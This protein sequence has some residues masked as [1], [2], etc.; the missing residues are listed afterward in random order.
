MARTAPPIQ[1]APFGVAAL[2]RW[3]RSGASAKDQSAA[4][5]AAGAALAALDPLAQS[6]SPPA[7]LWRDRLA[8][9]AAA[10]LCRIE[11]AR[12][13]LPE[14]RDHWCLRQP[15]DDPGPAGRRFAAFRLLGDAR[16]LRRCDW[17]DRL[18]GLFDLPPGEPLRRALAEAAAIGDTLPPPHA[19]AQAAR[20]I[21]TLGPDCRGLALWVGDAVLARTL[22][23]HRPL[24]LA[25]TA[26]PRKVLTRPEAGD[27]DSAWTTAIVQAAIGAHDLYRSL[28]TR[29]SALLD[30]APRLRGR[31][32][33]ATIS[34]LLAEDA[35]GAQ[36]GARASD[37]AARR[38][39]DR[40]TALGL[41]EEL[42]GRASF[43]LYGL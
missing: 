23:W 43:R 31:D 27:W 37:R 34:R 29:A 22:G 33:Q 13:S 42:T 6:P 21:A 8:L 16:A 35:I 17:P 5:H 40:L 36:A 19:A 32:A 1:I 10:A 20:R 4:L 2:P 39:F 3:I 26:V 28:A 14:I 24:A 9:H 41:V 11:G 15:D 30:A 7:S 18:P 25:A 38:L 12:E